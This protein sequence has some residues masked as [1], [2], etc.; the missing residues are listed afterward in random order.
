MKKISSSTNKVAKHL[1]IVVCMLLCFQVPVLRAQETGGA[2]EGRITGPGKKGLEAAA[3][4]LTHLPSATRYY[5]STLKDGQFYFSNL[6]VGGPYHLEV[7][8]VGM[9]KTDTTISKISLG[10]AQLITLQLTEN[11]VALTGITVTA[12]PRK[13][14]NMPIGAGEQI[15]RQVVQTMP[16]ISRSITDITRVVPQAT[17][18][19]SFAG[20]NFRYNNVTLDGAVNNDAIGFS[21]SLGG[22]TGTSNMPGS[23]TRTNPVSL[24]AIEEMQVYLSP[25]DIKIGNFTGGSINAVTRSGTNEVH[26][27]VYFFGRNA[28][29]TGPDRTNTEKEKRLPAAF[30]DWQTGARVGFP[31]VKDKLFFFTNIE[32]TD[33][34]EPVQQVAGSPGSDNILSRE[35]A[36][37]I[38]QHARSK[39][40]FDPGTDQLYNTYARSKKFFNRLD[41]NIN[42]RHQLVLRNNTVLSEALHMERDQFNFR[43]S[44]IGFRQ[45]N[46]QSATV[47]DLKSRIN[48]RISNN[49]IVGY[50]NIHD[51]REP[52]AR[53]DFPQV[54]IVGRTPG[55]T[56]FFGTDREAA[57][58]N[59]Q[60]K[61]F[62]FTDNVTVRMGKHTLT[63]GTHNEF[64]NIG[65]GFVNSWNGRVTYQSI[66]DFLSNNPQRV[67]GNYNYFNNSREYLYNHPPA[68]FR[69]NFLSA[70]V[71][72]EIRISPRFKIMPG[73]RIDWTHIP[74]KAPLSSRTQEAFRDPYF[75]TTYTYTPLRNI[76]Q[77]YLSQPMA[78]PRIG[79][80]ADLTESRSV[81]L[82]GGIGVFTGRIPLAWLGYAYYN[83]GN[84]FGSIDL[85]TNSVPPNPFQPGT[86]PLLRPAGSPYEGIAAFA[87]QQGR[88]VNDP[89]AGQTQVDVIDNNFVMPSVLRTSLAIDFTDQHGFN[90]SLE[91]IY[92]KTIRDVKFVQINLRDNPTYFAYDTALSLRKQPVYAGSVDPRLANGYLLTNT[93]KGFRYSL[94][95]KVSRRFDNGFHFSAAYTYGKSKDIS[96]GIRNS[97]ES[98][99]QLNQALNPNDPALALSNF[100]IRHRII[101]MLGYERSWSPKWRSVLSLFFSAQSGSPFTYGFVNYTPQNT[102]QQVG[103]AYI[104]ARGE[105]INFFAPQYA[106]D[107]KTVIS[108]AQ[109]QAAAFDQFIDDNKY[110]QSRRGNYTERNTGRTPWNVN[111]DLHFAQEFHLFT[112]KPVKDHHIITLTVD[113]MNF[114]NLINKEW[115]WAYFAPNTYNATASIGLQPYIPGR[116]AQG[117][118]L[119]QFKDPGKPYS[120]DPLASR[121]QMQL[122]L[123]YSL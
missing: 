27:S 67:Q 87:H 4:I 22:Q 117:Y 56:I 91:G 113:I 15:N 12:A 39:Y 44:S 79:F 29:L 59:L 76:N 54:Q 100:D 114:T 18:D 25:F 46:R 23:S 51:Y 42:E 37:K 73:L 43:F 47:L 52:T 94:T 84:T 68:N 93:S 70:Y 35:D 108:T 20:T 8:H 77:Q 118:P 81:V 3:V 53:A 75:G 50:T 98:N 9:K 34:Q 24:D 107:G 112:N 64:Y 105:T 121:W 49:L 32:M 38:V 97:M 102:P 103:L 41:W 106:A 62:E 78:S 92:T 80:R 86:D 11:T 122:G 109:E 45:V 40:N 7:T 13:S 119:Y 90:Y 89:N 120:I 61:T 2:L 72:D 99:W 66:A 63:A 31:I 19:N 36:D 115:G 30:Y 123:R 65:Y 33:R 10:D 57:V 104:P 48:N 74:E 85:R 82:R 21:P 5:L 60:Q 16:T 14:K 116:S 6:K 96:N 69:I 111:A 71:Q 58:F 1:L 101:A 95:G 55:T 26:G 17:K 28:S 88:V 83:T 110:L